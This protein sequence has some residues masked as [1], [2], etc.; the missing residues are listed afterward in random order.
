MKNNKK[1]QWEQALQTCMPIISKLASQLSR[2]PN[3]VIDRDDL[4]NCGLIGLMEATKA[5]E[6]GKDVKFS[7]F[8][9]FRIKGS[10]LDEIRK[11]QTHKRN[12]LEKHKKIQEAKRQMLHSKQEQSLSKT[13]GL[14]N[15][16]IEKINKIVS[17]RLVDTD[18][19]KVS[20]EQNTPENVV[21]L[22]QRNETLEKAVSKLPQNERNVINFRFHRELRLKEIGQELQLS[23]ARIHQLEKSA[24]F[25]LKDLCQDDDLDI[26]A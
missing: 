15:K 1:M 11:Y 14:S 26:A 6:A 8:A 20:N 5:Y 12:V 17:V 13:C 21:Q 16:E 22:K 25:K 23:E 4:I 7:T 24:L 18:I 3:S 2:V 9:Y 10:M 19:N